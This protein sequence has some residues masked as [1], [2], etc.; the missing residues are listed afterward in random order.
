[1]RGGGGGRR[2]VAGRPLAAGRNAGAP[3]LSPEPLT[4]KNLFR[5]RTGRVGGQAGQA[6][7]GPL[8]ACQGL[9]DPVKGLLQR[10]EVGRVRDAQ[11][12]GV[13]E[14]AARHEGYPGGL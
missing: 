1:M 4:A 8:D 10:A 9:F 7:S 11:A 3:S 12:F 13:A 14:G 2:Q 6:A 5:P